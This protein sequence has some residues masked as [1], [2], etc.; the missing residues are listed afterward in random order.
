MTFHG[1]GTGRVQRTNRSTLAH[2]LVY[3]LGRTGTETGDFHQLLFEFSGD[4]S[5]APL[6]GQN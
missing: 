4:L 2:L 1:S 6:S 5:R 3:R